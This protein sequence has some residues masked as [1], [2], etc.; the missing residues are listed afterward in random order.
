MTQSWEEATAPPLVVSI[1]QASGGPTVA[2][3]RKFDSLQRQW[4]GLKERRHTFEFDVLLPKYGQVQPPRMW[5]TPAEIKRFD[6]IID[7]EHKLIDAMH[8]LLDRI[9]P[10]SW[11]S[12]VGATHPFDMPWED[13]V[14]RGRLSKVP[15]VPYGGSE[16]QVRAFADALLS[17]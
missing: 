9:S 1:P 12:G 14:T 10:R 15:S 7:R 5:M 3:R 17:P 4:A 11:R 16:A 13:A 6:G 8:E 2:D